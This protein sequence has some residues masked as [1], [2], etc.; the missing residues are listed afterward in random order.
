MRNTRLSLFALLL[1]VASSLLAIGCGTSN[2]ESNSSS[3]PK[4]GNL[5]ATPGINEE[6]HPAGA[7][8]V[9]KSIASK[10]TLIVAADATYAPDE[11]IAGNGSTVEGM[12]A[13]LA[14]A[15]AQEMGL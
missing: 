1:L 4:S 5:T 10:G 11:F 7:S 6:K 13:D 3:S 14:K 15:I 12:D 8:K 2:D 9:P